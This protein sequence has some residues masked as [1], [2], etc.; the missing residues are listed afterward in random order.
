MNF[1]KSIAEQIAS[2]ARDGIPYLPG[3]GVTDA[4][5]AIQALFNGKT[6]RMPDGSLN[7]SLELNGMHPP[8]MTYAV[9]LTK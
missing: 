2:D 5:A 4:T 9:R 7:A 8:G 1:T 3:D 6:V